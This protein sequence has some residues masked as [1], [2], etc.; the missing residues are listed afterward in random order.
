MHPADLYRE[1]HRFVDPSEFALQS[2]LLAGLRAGHDR[3]M[4]R[5][6]A[7]T[8]R[9]SFS[10][11]QVYLLPAASWA[12]RVV[13]VFANRVARREPD[14]AHATLITNTDGSLLVSVRAPLDNPRGADSL[15]RQ[16]AT[17]GGRAAAA[18]INRLPADA[19][20]RFLAVFAA[21]FA[22]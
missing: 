14:L 19:L 17:G 18:G 22:V 5:A 2:D 8:P 16:F 7:L 3:D 1:V 6:E 20:D 21:H 9:W 12:R 13:G 10:A 11:G 4:A 15:C